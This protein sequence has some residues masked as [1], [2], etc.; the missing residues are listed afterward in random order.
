MGVV[1]SRPGN[2]LTRERQE[3]N[4]ASTWQKEKN[5][6]RDIK[7]ESGQNIVKQEKISMR[8]DVN[9]VC[10]V[11]HQ[12]VNSTAC[13]L[14]PLPLHHRTMGSAVAWWLPLFKWKCRSPLL[15]QVPLSSVQITVY[16]AWRNKKK[17][18]KKKREKVNGEGEHK[19]NI[20]SSLF[21]FSFFFNS[22]KWHVN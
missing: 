8:P 18:K 4:E 17:K 20:F 1:K 15:C 9:L 5:T 11:P 22:A 10:N 6:G 13:K 2:G 14:P 7:T 16:K 21:F 12:K 19:P 3:T